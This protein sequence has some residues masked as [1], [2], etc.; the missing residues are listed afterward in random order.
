VIRSY[1]FLIVRHPRAEHA[2]HIDWREDVA[3]VVLQAD[4]LALAVRAQ[5]AA[6]LA[7]THPV[8]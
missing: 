2:G 7:V 4:H 3:R 5:L 1:A 8:G 6:L